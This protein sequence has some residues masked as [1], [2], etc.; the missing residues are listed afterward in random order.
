MFQ[1][2]WMRRS[3]YFLLWMVLD[4]GSHGAFRIVEVCAQ[5]A[6]NEDREEK[7]EYVDR[8]V[9]IFGRIETMHFLYEAREGDVGSTSQSDH[10][11]MM[12]GT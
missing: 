1:P 10:A 2:F 12:V 3:I 7:G 11:P 8:D 4:G 9:V 5:K 6:Q